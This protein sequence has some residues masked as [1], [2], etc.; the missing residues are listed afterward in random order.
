MK[1]GTHPAVFTPVPT[2]RQVIAGMAVALGSLLVD[3]R[4]W[5]RAQPVAMQ[6]KPAM[7]AHQARTSLHY[8]IDFKPG[9]QRIY[10]ALLDAKQFAAF[11]GLP[12]EIDPK[13]GGAF[14]LFGGQ[15][16]G[17]HIELIAN[18]RIVQ[19]WR[20][21]HWDAGVYSIV[22]FELK[23][24][25]S[26]STLAFDHIGFPAGEFDHLDWGWHHHYWEPLKKFLG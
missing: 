12:A 21:T 25:G 17:R 10:E 26:E 15:I 16:V 5:A 13:P 20:P 18:Q 4:V 23:P 11:S 2:R 8:D 9:S 3:S 7:E 14:S 19:A 22:R 1:T 24:R 6:Q